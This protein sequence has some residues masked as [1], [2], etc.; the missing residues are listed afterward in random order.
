MADYRKL[1]VW[2]MARS[3]VVDVYRYT[4]QFPQTEKFNL[5]SQL[6]RASV[7]IAVNIAEG[8]GRGYDADFLKFIRISIGSLNEVETLMLLSIDLGFA[9]EQSHFELQEKMTQ[10]AVKLHNFEAR[11]QLTANRQR[12]TR[13]SLHTY[14]STEQLE[15]D[16]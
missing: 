3:I 6:Q 8:A 2:K 13:E 1:D 7:S 14:Q 11:L 16:L 9:T 4:E 12:F 10:L 15:S 5:T